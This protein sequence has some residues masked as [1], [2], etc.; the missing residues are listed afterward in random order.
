MR[1]AS[2]AK[3]LAALL[4]AWPAACRAGALEWEHTTVPVEVSPGR[5]GTAEF[6]FRNTSDHPVRI[7][8][9]PVSCGCMS[10]ALH[11]RDFAAG[12]KGSLPITYAPKGRPGV[13]AYRLYVVTDEKGQAPYELILEVH[14]TE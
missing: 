8:S 14:E 4:I 3:V 12:E 9:V 7:R 2:V 13:R 11:Q 6:V 5:K 1:P 10:P